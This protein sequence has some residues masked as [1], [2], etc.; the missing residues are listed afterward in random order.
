MDHLKN[1]IEEILNKLPDLCTVKDLIKVRLFSNDNHASSRRRREL[2]PEYFLLSREKILYPKTAVAEWMWYRYELSKKG[3]CKLTGDIY[4]LESHLKGGK[5]I[6]PNLF[7]TG[8][9]HHYL[10]DLGPV[11]NELIAAHIKEKSHDP[12][13]KLCIP[14]PEIPGLRNDDHFDEE[15]VYTYTYDKEDRILEKTKIES[16]SKKF[17]GDMMTIKGFCRYYDSFSEG[18]FHNHMRS[19]EKNKSFIDMAIRRLGPSS[20]FIEVQGLWDWF[21]IQPHKLSDLSTYLRN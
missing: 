17:P 1:A 13:E 19:I 14:E 8:E 15:E 9:Y 18:F 12:V 10:K 20:V 16:R 6:T 21:R 11:A 5:I 7:K 2:P 4:K 3:Y